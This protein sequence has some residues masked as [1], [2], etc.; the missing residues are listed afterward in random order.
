M[1]EYEL[2]GTICRTAK[3]RTPTTTIIIISK[4]VTKPNMVEFVFMDSK[5]AEMAPAQMARR[6]MVRTVVIET[7]SNSRSQRSRN[8]IQETGA[9]RLKTTS[10]TLSPSTSK[11]DCSIVSIFLDRS[12]RSEFRT[13]PVASAVSATESVD[14]IPTCMRADAHFSCTHNTVHISHIDT[15]FFNAV[16][17]QVVRNLCRAFLKNHFHLVVMSL[18]NLPFVCLSLHRLICSLSRPSAS[19]TSLERSRMNPCA[20]AHWSGMSGCLANPTPHTRTVCRTAP[21][22]SHLRCA[23]PCNAITTASCK[24]KSITQPTLVV[25][26]CMSEARTK[27]AQRTQT[28]AFEHPGLQKHHHTST[29]RPREARMER[30]FGRERGRNREFWAPSP[31]TSYLFVP[32]AGLPHLSPPPPN[33]LVDRGF[34]FGFFNVFSI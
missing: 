17:A 5:L 6:Q 8:S 10:S 31:S 28:C 21:D 34:F 3:F 7:T 12:C 2:G 19:S 18:L 27:K 9:T 13:Q 11:S 30:H 26:C 22:T 23:V 20:S 1:V 14:T 15:H 29:R 25:W 4:L 33:A 24:A 32:H 16:T